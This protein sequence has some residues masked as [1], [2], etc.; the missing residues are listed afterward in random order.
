M[1]GTIKDKTQLLA[2]FEPNQQQRITAQTHQ[3]FVESVLGAVAVDGP[4][5]ELET[6]PGGAERI[7]N[8]R[9]K[10]TEGGAGRWLALGIGHAGVSQDGDITT[11]VQVNDDPES[12]NYVGVKTYRAGEINKDYVMDWFTL[13][14]DDEVSLAFETP[15][16]VQLQAP[17]FL[18]LIFRIS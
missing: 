1:T 8:K 18:F 6:D 12:S 14:V 7:N 17:K 10:I 2:A 5:G 9:F 16:G 3:D 4:D 11:S 13:A 15:P